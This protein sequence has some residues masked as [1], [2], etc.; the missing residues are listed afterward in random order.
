MILQLKATARNFLLVLSLAP[1]LIKVIL[2]LFLAILV[3]YIIL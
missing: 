1:P 2:L 3:L